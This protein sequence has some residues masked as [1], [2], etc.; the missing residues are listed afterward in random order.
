MLY[1]LDG[2]EPIAV[3]GLQADEMPTAWTGEG[4]SLV[5]LVGDPPR[6]IVALNPAGGRR[7]PLKEIRP[8]DP[9]LFGPTQLV[10]TPDGKSYAA[11]YGRNQMTLFL[12][13]G[14]K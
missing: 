12:V 6:R 14:L 7:E 5:L 2:G 13:D 4:R 9:S 1:R 3:N 11:N 8:S 10:M